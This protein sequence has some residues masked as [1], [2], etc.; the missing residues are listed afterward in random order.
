MHAIKTFGFASLFAPLF[1]LGCAS[2]NTNNTMISDTQPN[3]LSNTNNPG[4][5]HER[6]ASSTVR[7]VNG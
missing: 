4:D 7:D 1:I 5:N 3:S 6:Y 2:T